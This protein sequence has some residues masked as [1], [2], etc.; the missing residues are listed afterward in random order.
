MSA[1]RSF[2]FSRNGSRST[3][4]TDVGLPYSLAIDAA[5]NLF[6]SDWDTGS[7]YKFSPKGDK[8]TF[9]STEIAAKILACD[10]AGNL[11]AG[12][13]LKHSIFKYEP[14]GGKSDFA[15]GLTTYALAVDKAGNVYVGDTGTTIFKIAPTRC[16]K[17][18]R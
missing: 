5:G 9:A 10:D 4:A 15:T 3:F 2:K 1:A 18:F 8:S 11:F 12:V 13:P 7:I 16:Q 6:V 14:R 17:R